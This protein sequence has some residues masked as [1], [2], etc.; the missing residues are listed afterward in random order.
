MV[1]SWR[2]ISLRHVEGEAPDGEA[3]S[4]GRRW[5]RNLR[6]S[7]LVADANVV[8][9]LLAGRL[10]DLGRRGE[11]GS[12]GVGEG[13]SLCQQRPGYWDGVDAIVVDNSDI[14]KLDINVRHSRNVVHGWIHTE[15]G[16]DSRRFV[17]QSGARGP[18]SAS[19]RAL[20]SDC[21]PSRFTMGRFGGAL[22]GG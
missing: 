5:K 6:F 20:S 7:V 15:D 11:S 2:W 17:L 21:F 10:E 14:V 13:S 3:S 4:D 16:V 22:P 1:T 12:G 8:L 18:N 9:G 19:K